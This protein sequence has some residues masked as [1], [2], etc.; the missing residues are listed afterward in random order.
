MEPMMIRCKN[1]AE[2]LTS[3]RL[4]KSGVGTRLQVRMHLW[5]CRHCARFARQVRSMGA[6]ASKL[7]DAIGR[8]RAGAAGDDLESRLLRKVSGR[9]R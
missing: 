5:L 6:A 3:D 4:Q 7:A 1:V 2:L 8:E 9:E